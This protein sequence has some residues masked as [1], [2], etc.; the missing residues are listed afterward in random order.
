LRLRSLLAFGVGSCSASKAGRERYEQ[1]PAAKRASR[2]LDECGRRLER[3][4][5]QPTR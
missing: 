4:S 1:N 3:F 2:R 5:N